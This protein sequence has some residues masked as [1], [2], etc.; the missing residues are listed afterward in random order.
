M[1][2]PELLPVYLLYITWLLYFCFHCYLNNSIPVFLPV[3]VLYKF[4]PV[5]LPSLYYSIFV[6]V[7]LPIHFLYHLFKY[8]CIHCSRFLRNEKFIIQ[9]QP[10]CFMLRTLERPIQ[11]TFISL[12]RIRVCLCSICITLYSFVFL[13]MISDF[14]ETVWYICSSERNVLWFSYKCK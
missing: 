5:R 12:Y 2:V 9:R 13:C 3:N 7:L 14:C 10:L 4:F 1:T 8:F 6:P 11:M